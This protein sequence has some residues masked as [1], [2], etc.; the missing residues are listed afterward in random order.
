MIAYLKSHL[1]R[2]TGAIGKA[3]K[4]IRSE[5]KNVEGKIRTILSS[6]SNN[7]E[8]SVQS[9]FVQYRT[10]VYLTSLNERKFVFRTLLKDRKFLKKVRMTSEGLGISSL[11]AVLLS[12]PTIIAGP[13]M[14]PFAGTGVAAGLAVALGA[15]AIEWMTKHMLHDILSHYTDL[16]RMARRVFEFCGKR[17]SE[18][19]SVYVDM[20]KAQATQSAVECIRLLDTVLDSVGVKIVG[21]KVENVPPRMKHWQKEKDG[22]PDATLMRLFQGFASGR[23]WWRSHVKDME[24]YMY[25]IC[26]PGYTRCENSMRCVLTDLEHIA[27]PS[28]SREGLCKEGSRS[29]QR[30]RD[31]YLYTTRTLRYRGASEE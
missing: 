11:A 8:E 22:V 23:E 17:K 25:G 16:M 15:T 31:E 20:L 27:P 21:D 30:T 3:K 7:N 28:V 10:F 18:T 1:A 5:L 9:L 24:S 26:P 2:L 29:G 4:G 13:H 12:M 19:A 6:R 14:L